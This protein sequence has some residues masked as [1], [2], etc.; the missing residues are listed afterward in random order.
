MMKRSINYAVA[1]LL[2][3]SLPVLAGK[4]LQDGEKEDSLLTFLE[5][6]YDVVG[7][8]PD[9]GKTY[10]G[11]VTL[12]RRGNKLLMTRNIR[13]RKTTSSAT[14]IA[15][16]ADAIRVLRADFMENRQKLQATYSIGSDADN[17]ARLTG[18]VYIAGRET[19]EP[20]MEALFMRH[21]AD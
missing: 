20:G 2:I 4:P 19:R 15:I 12:E 1:L 9:G 17:Y 5:G 21:S 16:T 11:T 18:R 14:L 6:S 8:Y 13:G 3:L 7:K 10:S